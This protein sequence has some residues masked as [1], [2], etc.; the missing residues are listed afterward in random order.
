MTLGEISDGFKPLKFENLGVSGKA[1]I[2]DR[3][4]PVRL[5]DLKLDTG[6]F[7]FLEAHELGFEVVGIETIVE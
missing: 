1:K 3:G 6:F 2:T 4:K 7:L 5:A